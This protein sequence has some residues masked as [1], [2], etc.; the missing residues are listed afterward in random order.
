[1]NE[2]LEESLFF[3]AFFTI[4][5]YFA[6]SALKRRFKTALF[7]PLLIAMAIIIAV[8]SVF[9]IDYG[10]YEKGASYVSFFLT[11]ATVCL[12]VPLYRQLSVLKKHALAVFCGILSGVLTN[13]VLVLV[14]SVMLKLNHVQYVTILPKSITTPIGVGIS[15]EL[16]GVAA[17]TAAVIV[18]TGVLGNVMSEI[19]CRIFGIKE[20]VAQGIALGSA[21]HV[22][23]TAK[24]MEVGETQGALSSLSIV[25]SGLITVVFAPFFASLY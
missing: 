1:M 19:L 24:A 9:K 14:L 17:I 3:G 16:G 20:P 13:A 10:I 22:V 25:V 7:N 15:N 8:L 12:A 5:A 23:G 4:L 2:F 18:I 6:G 21:S 11:P